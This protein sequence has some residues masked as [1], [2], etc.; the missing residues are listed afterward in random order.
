[1]YVY[2]SQK[3]VFGS[4]V[5]TIEKPRLHLLYIYEIYL[6]KTCL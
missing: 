2:M 3:S 5:K 6:G 1:M 4:M